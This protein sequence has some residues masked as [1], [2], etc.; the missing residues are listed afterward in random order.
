MLCSAF[1]SL[2]SS[3]QDSSGS[4][5]TG[6]FLGF[7]EYHFW[8]QQNDLSDTSQP[9]GA[10]GVIE[11]SA[12]WK[13]LPVRDCR[14][15]VMACHFKMLFHKKP[16]LFLGVGWGAL[17]VWC[18]NAWCHSAHSWR[19][20]LQESLSPPVTPCDPRWFRKAVEKYI[21]RS[22]ESV[23]EMKIN[24]TGDKWDLTSST[25]LIVSYNSWDALKLL[26][27]R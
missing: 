4:P 11:H 2:T 26:N 21:Q 7:K 27:I 14:A 8:S 18:Q 13:S 15:S 20:F 16:A 24:E 25:K 12:W 10:D 17:D 19:T 9:C 6:G 22:T 5:S 3:R 1:C 23:T